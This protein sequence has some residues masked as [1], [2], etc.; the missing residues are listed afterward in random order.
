MPLDTAMTAAD[1]PSS[2][3][4][5]FRRGAT[6]I[7]PIMISAGPFG[8]VFGALAAEKGIPFDQIMLM[9]ALMYAGAS[10]M[11]AVELWAFPPPFWTI[12]VAVLAV[13]FRHVLYSAAL[14]RKMRGWPITRR[15]FGFG[16]MVDPVYALADAQSPTHLSGAYYAGMTVMLYPMWIISSAVGAIFGNRI[17]N[18]ESWGIDFVLVTY[19]T[20]LVLGFKGRP[21]AFV[22]IVASTVVALLVYLTIGAPWHVASGGFAG[23][24]TAAALAVPKQDAAQETQR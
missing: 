14:G 15:F 24:L 18:P 5:H 11:V 9:S 20:V 21:N 22:I 19:F 8:L 16:F 7:V 6:D 12:L 17:E 13:N 2:R 23:I 3:I 1:D 4:Q 10:Q